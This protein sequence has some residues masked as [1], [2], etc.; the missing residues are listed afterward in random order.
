MWTGRAG[1]GSIRYWYQS[2][3]PHPSR[4]QVTAVMHGLDRCLAACN[5]F[6]FLAQ[7]P[8]QD[9]EAA[10]AGIVIAIAQRLQQRAS[11][12]GCPRLKNHRI[13]QTHLERGDLDLPAAGSAKRPARAVQDPFARWILSRGGT[14]RCP[15]SRPNWCRDRPVRQPADQIAQGGGQL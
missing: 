11:R 6:D 4:E 9:V 1:S 13:E 2:N 3:F 12:N 5:G 10:P 7:T 15:A 14:V 8:D